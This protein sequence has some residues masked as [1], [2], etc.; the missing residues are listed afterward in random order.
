MRIPFM[1]KVV[2]PEA[3]IMALRRQLD[4]AKRRITE[5][6]LDNIQKTNEIAMLQDY[7]GIS[8]AMPGKNMAVPAKPANSET[9]HVLEQAC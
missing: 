4:C 8:S 9:G 7:R 3:E 5:L 6:T 1:K 2:G